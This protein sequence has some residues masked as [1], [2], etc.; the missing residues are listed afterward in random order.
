MV[1][2]GVNQSVERK[3]DFRL[4]TGTG[5]YTDDIDLDGQLYGYMLRSPVAH[6]KVLSIDIDEAR[7]APGVVDIILGKELEADKANQLPCMIPLKNR[8]GSDRADPGHPVLATDKVR[9]VGD[10]VAFVIAETLTQ[11]KDAA[12]LIYVDF[13]EEDVIVDT[14]TANAPGQPLVHDNVPNNVA[15]DWEQGNE[16]NIQDVFSNASHVTEIELI[17]NR[18]VVNSM[19][20]RGLIA[21][22]DGDAAKMTVRMGTQ[23]GWVLRSL[24]AN[25]ILHVPEE[26]IRVITPDVGGAFGMKLFFYSECAVTVWA[27]R[28]LGRPVKW[29]GERSDAFLSDT[30]GRDHV[31]RAK[32][33]FDAN[34][35]ITGMKVETNANLGAY[36]STFGPLI[37]TM[38]AVKVLPGVYDIPNFYYRS[39][40]VFTNTVPVDAYRG[41]GR[42]E[43]IYVIER[44]MDTAARELGLGQDEIRR[45]NFIPV[46]AIPYTTSTGCVYDSGE[47]ERIMDRA[48]E[49]SD[50]ESFPD[51]RAASAEHGKRRGIGMCYY[52]EA[53]AGNP[54][55]TATIRFEED[56]RVTVAVGT[57]SSGQGHS[58]AYAQIVAERLGVP[59]ENIEIVQG[60]TDK[61]KSGGGTGGSRSLTTQ[62]PA[63]HAASDEVINKGKEL[64]GHF[65]EAA[66]VDIEFS[67]D[68]GEFA[69][70][71]TD[72]KIGILELAHRARGLGQLPENL[73]E[74]LDSE[75]SFTVEAF[76]YPN[77]CH[78]AEVEIDELTGA[79][80]VVRYVIVDDFGTI[81]NPALVRNQVI[82]GVGQGIGQAL[83]EHTVYSDDGQLL[84]GSYMDYGMPRADNIPLDLLYET[85]EVPCTMNPMGVKGCGEAGCIGAPPAV[86]NAIIDGL[87]DLGVRHI[88]MPATPQRVW[89]II[90]QAS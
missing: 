21:D 82:G 87:A 39:I 78:I 33:A 46:S 56:D 10:N 57:Q 86:I 74:G 89:D 17:N 9:Y 25:A 5:E 77:G 36:L 23:G 64:A 73:A 76:T 83:T 70:A 48:L 28:K 26:D 51:R 72:R 32:L 15:F 3:E 7:Q 38:A 49:T 85:V 1:K 6:G 84:T 50:W 58:T 40:G 45:K 35:K 80:E 55:E 43:A 75:A 47:F 4:I 69:I 18:V 88:D 22:W 14:K 29:I 31:T 90:Q 59:F 34:H 42:P 11:A 71:G 12:E 66:P 60:D 24:L 53:T 27:S 16:K 62:G 2:F 81:V 37:P 79:A 30:Q 63:I 8:D 61:I 68:D 52:I 41:A 13:E 67:A 65:L 19:E 54:T 44:L 20:P